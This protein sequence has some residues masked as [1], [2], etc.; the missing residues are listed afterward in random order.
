MKDIGK[1]KYFLGIEITREPM[2]IFLTQRKYL[3]NII[4]EARL[5]E[6]KR[7][8]TLIEH[9]HRLLSNKG[10]FYKNPARFRRVWDDLFILPSHV[11]SCVMRFMLCLMRMNHGRPIG[12]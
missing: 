11:P 12:V 3:L 7:V 4:T 10:P 8:F 6:C 5:L 1:I 2:E 9:N